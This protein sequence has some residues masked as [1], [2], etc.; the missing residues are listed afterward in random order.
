MKRNIVIATV[1]AAALI[2]GGTVAAV[3]I[4]GDDTADR[5]G[6]S[7]RAVP[8][9][10]DVRG[11]ADD[12]DGR[13]EA[14]DDRRVNGSGD[15]RDGAG[16][17]DDAAERAAARNA[18]VT[19]AEAI[20][21]ALRATPGTAVS[22]ELDDRDGNRGPVWEVEVL[23][24]DDRWHS[25]HIDPATGTVLSTGTEDEDDTAEVRAALRG[26]SVTAAEAAR[27][28]AARGTVV[29]VD[30]DEDGADRGWEVETVDASGT[31]E[32]DWTVDLATGKVTADRDDD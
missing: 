11:G 19:A 4:G 15:R 21:A 17:D 29:S 24:G 23:T 22:A 27:A 5:T 8:A 7:A 14:G 13:R 28:A 3:A 16:R 12:R 30:L 25:V 26:A 18:D 6:V 9:D 31:G 2:T 20:A 32:R 10:D 1:A